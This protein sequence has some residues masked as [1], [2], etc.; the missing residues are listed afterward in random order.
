[1]AKQSMAS[2]RRVM[3]DDKG[4]ILFVNGDTGKFLRPAP[5]QASLNVIE[6][7][8][9]GI[10]DRVIRGDRAQNKRQKI[11]GQTN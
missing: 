3:A 6:M 4:N 1:M 11:P 8:R 5:G 2:A 9:E 10:P 7:A